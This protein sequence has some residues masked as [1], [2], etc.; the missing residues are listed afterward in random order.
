MSMEYRPTPDCSLERLLANLPPS[1]T[2]VFCAP[3]YIAACAKLTCDGHFMWAYE[4]E[5]G[6]AHAESFG[7]NDARPMLLLLSAALG[8]TWQDEYTNE[9]GAPP[10]V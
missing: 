3:H 8:V 1:I 10:S 5:P 6:K 2:V 4:D 7:R 9:I